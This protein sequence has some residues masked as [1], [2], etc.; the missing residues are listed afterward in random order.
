MTYQEAVAYIDETPKFT[1]KNTLDH[2]RAFLKRL[3]DPQEKMK[4][5]HVAGTNGKGSVCSFLASM[6]KAGGKRTGLFTSPHLVKINERFVVDEQD[7]SDEEFLEAFHTVMDCVEEMKE[8]GYPHPTY[9]ELLF[10]IGMKL[11]ERAGVEYLVLETG[12]GGRLDATNSVAH[13]LVSVITSISLDHTEYL[14]DT[15]AAIAGEK[16]G[17]IKEGVPVVYDASCPES[18]EVIRRRAE[19]LRAPAYPITPKMYKISKTT[20]KHID[21]SIDSGYYDDIRL[22]ISSVAEYQVKNAAEAVTAIRVIDRE[23]AFTD[24]VIRKGVEEMRW[25]GRMETVLPGVIIDG[26][27]NEA[28]VEEFVKT[29]RRLEAD[30]PVTLL[31]AAVGDKD[32]RHMIETICREL[33]LERVIVTEVGGYR[34]VDV[35]VPEELFRQFGAKKVTAIPDV[36]EAFDEALREQGDGILFCVGSLYLVGNIKSILE[37]R[38]SAHD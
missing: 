29:A 17:I 31:F 3:G 4:I 36:E 21:F 10:L 34:S 11:F 27:H 37:T 20:K 32:Y 24:E 18:A 33:R 8:E 22:S 23:G 13:P 15:V 19:E 28:G 6:L 16:A 7:V 1:K 9:F 26:A 35:K 14:G 30:Y 38:R 25:Q 2:T 12:L 5:L